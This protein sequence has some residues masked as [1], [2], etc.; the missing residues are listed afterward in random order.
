[1]QRPFQV[2][3]VVDV[4]QHGRATVLEVRAIGAAAGDRR[5]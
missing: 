4:K 1:M 3:D 5:A 2:G